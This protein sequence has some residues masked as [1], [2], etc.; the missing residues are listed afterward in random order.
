MLTFPVD[1]KPGINEDFQRIFQF[2]H[3]GYQ[4]GFTC[5]GRDDHLN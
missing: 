4:Q 3:T 1:I 2:L 5:L